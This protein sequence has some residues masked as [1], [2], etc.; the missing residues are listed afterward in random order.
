MIQ[1]LIKF[2]KIIRW[3][4]VSLYLLL[5]VLLY[6][7]WFK[8][9][10]VP[11]DG[12]LFLTLSM[13]FFGIFGNIQNNLADYDRDRF[14]E[15]FTDFNQTLYF[16]LMLIS[17]IVAF[18]FGFTAFYLTFAPSLLYAII[19][20]PVLLSLYNYYLKKTPL[21]GNFMIAFITV[22]AIFIPLKF[23][24]NLSINNPYIFFLLNM[25]FWLSLLRELVKDM[26]DQDLDGR[27]GYKTLPVINL[28]L[29]RFVWMALSIITWGIMFLY[30]NEFTSN[31][32]HILLLFSA[33]ILS[34]TAYLI[35]KKQYELS[36]KLL[37][38]LMLIGIFSI[39]FF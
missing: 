28:P 16:I 33:I 12:W 6:F 7:V 39:F 36:T 17:L 38:L 15:N 26:E 25:S 37:K 11:S 32:Y 4:N 22:L 35:Y 5:Q 31:S 34:A 18:I 14:K 23:T 30:K 8:K 3:K 10:L 1:P 29:S 2:F 19:S 13:I 20:I 27:F 24:K 9:Q 21:I